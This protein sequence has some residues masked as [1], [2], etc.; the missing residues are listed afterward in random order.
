MPT[1]SLLTTVNLSTVKRDYA[2]YTIATLVNCEESYIRNL[3][4]AIAGA[5]LSDY[6]KEYYVPFQYVKDKAT[7]KIKKN[8]GDYSGYVFVKCI[9]TAKV[10]NTL[11]TT[12]GVAVVLTA[13]EIPAEIDADS[14][15]TIRQHNA[16]IGFTPDEAYALKKELRSQY[17]CKGVEKP[18]LTDTDFNTD[19]TK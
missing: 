4:D 15:N 11:R 19:F 8:K 17:K 14:L 9:L 16:P 6:V 5:G 2:W 1:R 18:Q 3:K 13:G 12:R 10:W 7:G